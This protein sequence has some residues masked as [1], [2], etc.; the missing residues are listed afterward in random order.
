MT[1]TAGA[2]RTLTERLIRRDRAV[3]AAS[4]GLLALLSWIY[5]LLGA[6]TGMSTLAMTTWAFP[7][8][9]H[10]FAPMPWDAGY[11][12]IMLG[13]W[14]VMMIAMML[15]AA[16][17][18]VLLHAATLRHAQ[19]RGQSEAAGVPSAMFVAG[20]L[21]VWLAFSAAAV[22]SQWALER[23]GLVHQMLMWS[24][25]TTFSG[26]LLLAAGV[27]QLTPLKAA[28]LE[29][30]RSPAAWLSE[31]WRPG[32][33]GALRM[34][35]RHGAWC[36]GCCWILMALLFAGGTMNLLWIAGLSLVVLL[37][38]LAPHGHRIARGLGILMCAAGAWLLLAG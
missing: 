23:A 28:C 5:I 13:M 24:T 17:P 37:E 8:P 14:W 29:H 30:C 20:Y 3:L 16:A 1:A 27:Y 10:A 2:K 12:I 11:W 21:A 31:N 35:L 34:G 15:P 9:A 25:S 19:A 26:L 6:G 4:L 22:A 38:K 32:P 18:V 7:P 36:L 33:A